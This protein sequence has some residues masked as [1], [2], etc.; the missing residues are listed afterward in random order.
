MK[1][2]RLQVTPLRKKV[3]EERKDF[4]CNKIKKSYKENKNSIGEKINKIL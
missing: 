1:K 4:K 3:Y 2:W